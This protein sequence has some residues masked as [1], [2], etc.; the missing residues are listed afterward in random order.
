MSNVYVIPSK[1][2]GM[3]ILTNERN[4]GNA[5][6][7][8]VMHKFNKLLVGINDTDAWPSNYEAFKPKSIPDPVVYKGPRNLTSYTGVY[9]NKFYGNITIKQDNNHL[10]CYYGH[11]KQPYTL[12]HWNDTL[13]MEESAATYFIEFDNLTAGKYQKL[14]TQFPDYSTVP[15]NL[16]SKFKRTSNT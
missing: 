9:F 13:F 11:N 3:V 7:N 6:I 16:T 4:Y 15:Q 8:S 12:K 2:I 14:V 10:V 1:G 5:F